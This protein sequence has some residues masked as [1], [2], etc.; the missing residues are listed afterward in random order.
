[1]SGKT[2][3]PPVR[4]YGVFDADIAGRSLDMALLRRLFGWL[5]PHRRVLLVSGVLVVFASVLAIAMPVL[6]SRVV[7]D[8]LLA[9]SQ[10]VALPDLGLTAASAKLGQWV[11]VGPIWAACGL[12]FLLSSLQVVSAHYHR[13]TLARGMLGA[14]RDLRHDLFLHLETRPASFYDRVAV[15]RVMTRVTNDVEQLFQLLSGFGVLLGEFA[16]FIVALILMLSISAELTGVLLLALPIVA[17]GT[18]FYRRATRRV[19]RDIRQSVSN[20]NQNLAENISGMPVVQLNRREARNLAR[21]SGINRENREQEAHAIRLETWYGAMMENIGPAA[22]GVIIWI[23]GGDALQGTISLGSMIL[24]SQFIDMLIRPVVV[25]GE[26]YNVLFR[27]MAS[28]ER[29]FQALDWDE[30]IH[31]PAAPAALPTSLAGQIEFRHLTFG[32]VPDL[33]VLKD[34]HFTVRPGE[35]LAIVG[36]TG[37]GKSTIIRLLARF[38]DVAPGSILLDGVDLMDVPSATVR[39][40]IGIVLQDFHVFA[41]TVP[42]N[43]SLGDPALDRARVVAAAQLANAHE[44]ITGLPAAYD[45]VLAERGQTLSQGQRQLLAFARV[46]AA[47]PDILVL[48]EATASI[49]TDTETLIQSALAEL[50]RGRTSIIIAH[51]LQTIQNAD[52]VLVLEWGRVTELGTPAELMALGGTYARLH[53]LQFQEA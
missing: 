10:P 40:R 14:L 26:Q 9:S 53:A 19:Y 11:G 15:G 52:R 37:S 17:V 12:Y 47:R 28:G 1:M 21:Y 7:I 48:D 45:T 30:T 25:V 32:Y 39:K 38:Y 3:S 23:G 34:V 18:W 43:I 4:D 31:E 46:L 22:M 33:P 41:G 51:R 5:R 24:F 29:I 44:F 8:G 13:V 6:V 42:D 16:P 20:M 49:D 50:T 27:A 35:R 36:P 2:T